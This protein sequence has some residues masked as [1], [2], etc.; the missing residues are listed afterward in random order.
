MGDATGRESAP[1]DQVTLDLFSSEGA[2]PAPDRE[3]RLSGQRSAKIRRILDARFSLSELERIKA[4]EPERWS[5]PRND[6]GRGFYGEALR[7][8]RRLEAA[9]DELLDAEIAALA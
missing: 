5:A 1:I 2:P 3:Q 7:E 4:E 6:M 9:D 8:A